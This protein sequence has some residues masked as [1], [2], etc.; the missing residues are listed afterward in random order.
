M[1][2][3]NVDG[4]GRRR[5]ATGASLQQ[6]PRKTKY[7][8]FG[9][10]FL[11]FSCTKNEIDSF[12]WL[13]PLFCF[14]FS[15]W[16]DPAHSHAGSVAELSPS[17]Y[18]VWALA[19][20]LCW[21]T[22][23]CDVV[24]CG[25]WSACCWCHSEAAFVTW[26]DVFFLAVWVFWTGDGQCGC[27]SSNRSRAHR[28]P[29]GRPLR[30]SGFVCRW[31]RANAALYFCELCVN[32]PARAPPV[33][34]R[35]RGGVNLQTMSLLIQFTGMCKQSQCAGLQGRKKSNLQF[36]TVQNVT[37][38]PA[39]VF[40]CVFVWRTNNHHIHTRLVFSHLLWLID[41]WGPGQ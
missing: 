12:L 28:S 8:K 25:G 22:L 36:V 35:P 24:C 2:Q 34:V 23:F 9:H 41:K 18:T 30:V 14:F 37:F 32:W 27:Q 1:T 5:P 19:S 39:S 10:V 7:C 13:K 38:N 11:H 4:N 31:L 17:G 26:L 33:R 40:L 3:C 20:R 6:W 29:Q 15:L 21:R 16:K